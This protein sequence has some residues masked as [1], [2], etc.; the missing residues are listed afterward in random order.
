MKYLETNN[1][2][3]EN[4]HGFRSCHSTE[5]AL[6]M[7]TEEIHRRVDGGGKAVLILLDLSAT[8]DTVIHQVLEGR[9]RSVGVGGRAL[10]L[11]SSFL[12]DRQ[13]S[14]Q[15]GELK[16]GDFQTPCGV[17]QGSALSPTLFN[18]YVAPLAALVRRYGFVFVSYADDSQIVISVSKQSDNIA[19]DFHACL[20]YIMKWMSL[21]YLKINTEKTE[22]MELDNGP[23]VWNSAWWPCEAGQ[24]PVP[25]TKVKSLGVVFDV[26]LN[27]TTQIKSVTSACFFTLKVLGKIFPFIPQELQK[28]VVLALVLSQL[29]YCN[30]L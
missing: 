4:R 22:V 30:A 9:L 15:W 16:S 25:S 24:C 5:T 6:I 23:S 28:S 2:L 11:L 26:Q 14:V 12:S 7:A 10:S 1:L 13:Q 8:F 27:M 20:T 17:P 3:D 29:D 18:I 21:S 19:L